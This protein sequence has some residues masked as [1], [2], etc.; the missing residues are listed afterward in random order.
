[1]DWPMSTTTT[2]NNKERRRMP[3]HDTPPEAE[4]NRA[5]RT[6]SDHAV[7]TGERLLEASTKIGNACADAYQEAV[8]SMAD[9][10]EK[11]ADARPEDWQNLVQ[12]PAAVGAPPI[13]APLRNAATAA[14]R[15]NEEIVTAGKR[16]SL[17]YVE[18]CQQAVLKAVELR[19]QAV[20]AS[21]NEWLR[22]LGSEHASAARDITRCYGDVLRQLVA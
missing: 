18:A 21:G 22:S 8:V 2:T 12:G 11:I 17:A 9:F 1:M 5:Q 4:P 14:S 7:Q 13:A 20:T 15:A 3:Q 10:R 16:L 6:L 19:E